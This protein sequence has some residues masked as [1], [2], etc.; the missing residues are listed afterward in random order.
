[1]SELV[2]NWS[3]LSYVRCLHGLR[4]PHPTT[5]VFCFGKNRKRERE[6]GDPVTTF[7]IEKKKKLY[8]SLYD[9]KGIKPVKI[10]QNTLDLSWSKWDLHDLLE[11]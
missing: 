10:L 1:M 2:D 8:F 3:E 7:P 11:N 6:R 9:M 5:L 4:G